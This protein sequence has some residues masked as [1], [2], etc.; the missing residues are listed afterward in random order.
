MPHLFV[1]RPRQH[2]LFA[3][4][5]E[6]ANQLLW[7]SINAFI[8]K[9]GGLLFIAGSILFFPS[10]KAYVDVG[11]WIFIVG[12]L[13]YLVVT[14][15]DVLEVIRHARLR[16]R[17][18]TIWDRLE[19]GAA[20][21]Y[22]TGTILFTVGSVFF[23]SQVALF[24]PGAWCFVSGSLLFLAGATINVLQ[25]TRAANLLTLQLMNLTALTYVTGSLL[26]VVASVP[27]LWSFDTVGDQD[28]VGTFLAWQYVVG[29][30]LFFLGGVFNYW[31]ALIVIRSHYAVT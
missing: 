3:R 4:D 12:S 15:H 30:A 24:R 31:R 14:G 2:D 20:F 11:A 10:L 19:R 16:T 6:R 23:L 7:E 5:P 26:F 27:Y 25:I 8:Y 18:P 29:S 9:L 13:L 1:N 28:K 17:P 22:F 21:T